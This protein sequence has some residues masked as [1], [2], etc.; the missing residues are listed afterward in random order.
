M[1]LALAAGVLLV[2]ICIWL[3]AAHSNGSA[4]RSDSPVVF[5]GVGSQTTD[6]FH[7]AGGTYRGLWSAWGQTPA[8]PPCTHSVELLA[9]DPANGTTGT[10]HV[11]DLA[12]LVHVPSTGQSNETYVINVKPGDY[13]LGVT[14]ACAWQVAFTPNR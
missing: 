12:R 8:D 5:A 14:S 11:T 9:V 6:H 4:E 1:T 10:G 13:Y 7:L 3:Y 2:G